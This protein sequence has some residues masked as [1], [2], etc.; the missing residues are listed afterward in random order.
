M[1]TLLTCH[2]VIPLGQATRRGTPTACRVTAPPASMANLLVPGT[3]RLPR[4]LLVRTAKTP[5]PVLSFVPDNAY[6]SVFD[7]SRTL[8]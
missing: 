6:S 7:P 8:A 2:V 5:F 3:W 1:Q 4:A